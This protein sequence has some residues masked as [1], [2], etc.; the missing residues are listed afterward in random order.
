MKKILIASDSFKESL[1]AREVCTAMENGLKKGNPF[2]F[3]K[4]F[5][6]SDGGEGSVE[7]L[8]LHIP[9]ALEILSVQNPLGRL[10]EAKYAISKDG[11]TAIIEMAQAAGLHL[12]S[13]AERN[14]LRTTSFGVGQLIG[15]ACQK[16]VKSIVLCIGGSATND[17]GAGMAKALGFRFLDEAGNEISPEGGQLS[18]IEKIENPSARFFE[19][20]PKVKVLCDVDNPLFGPKGAAFVYAPQ[21]GADEAQVRILDEGLRH[22]SGV[23]ERHFKKDYSQIPGAGAAGGMGAGAMAFLNAQLCPGIQTIM[24]MTHFEKALR[25]ADMVITGEG[26]LDGQT[27]SGKLIFG[28]SQLA[29]K[30]QKPLVVFCGKNELSTEKTSKMGIEKVIPISPP[31]MNLEEAIAKTAEFLELEAQKFARGL[32]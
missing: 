13:K 23:L 5:P 11:K 22:F 28:I 8:S 15:D 18:R 1:S 2:L 24:E 16:G 26:K 17:V 29:R 30:Y 3:C 27:M 32:E 9:S 10:V 14:P 25:Q 6:L 31:E 12:L 21:K 4:T 20:I 19:K 7:V